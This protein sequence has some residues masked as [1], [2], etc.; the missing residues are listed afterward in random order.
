MSPWQAYRF[1][2]GPRQAGYFGGGHYA[3]AGHG[4]RHGAG[5]WQHPGYG[6]RYARHFRGHAGPFGPG[7]ARHHFH[8]G[9]QWAGHGKVQTGPEAKLAA[10]QKREAELKKLEDSIKT[11]LVSLEKKQ[12]ELK[13]EIQKAAKLEAKPEAKPEEKK[14]AEK[15]L[16]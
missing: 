10:L 2:Y 1:G 5:G 13:A 6:G 8:Q 12:E 14:P 4:W 9:G 7:Y 3:H 16:D 15:K 11:R